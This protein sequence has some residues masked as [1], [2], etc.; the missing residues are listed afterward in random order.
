MRIRGA[1]TDDIDI[2]ND[3]CTDVTCNLFCSHLVD[4][5]HSELS[6]FTLVLLTADSFA[7]YL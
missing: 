6:I 2:D 1:K 5:A 3:A 7:K 4:K